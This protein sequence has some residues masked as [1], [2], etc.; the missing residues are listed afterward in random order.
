MTKLKYIKIDLEEKVIKQMIVIIYLQIPEICSC[1]NK[2]IN[3]NKFNSNEKT[4]FCFRKHQ[5]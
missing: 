4:K 5:I 2:I 1:G 3:L